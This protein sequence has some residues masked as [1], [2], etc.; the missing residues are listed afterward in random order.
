MTQ[1]DVPQ[2]TKLLNKH[3]REQY[4]FSVQMTE[5]EASH[6]LLKRPDVV[7]SYVCCDSNVVT[8]MVSY[9]NLS[10]H[11]FDNEIYNSIRCAYA[12]YSFAKDN[13]T[14]RIVQLF[15]DALVLA[16]RD[17][18]DSFNATEVCQHIQMVETLGFTKSTCTGLHHFVYNWRLPILKGDQIG[19]IML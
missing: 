5:D 4:E 15:R 9:Y 19:L 16:K 7:Y 17:G 14:E 3:M 18:F 2:V 12:W 1:A 11:V 8:D 6:W 13:R 10:S